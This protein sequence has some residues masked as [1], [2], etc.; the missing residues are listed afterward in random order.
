MENSP[1]TEKEIIFHEYQV[2]A[3]TNECSISLA[4]SLFPRLKDMFIAK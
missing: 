3:T 4:G 1:V 2:F